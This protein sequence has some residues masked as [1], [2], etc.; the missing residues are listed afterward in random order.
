MDGGSVRPVRIRRSSRLARVFCPAILAASIVWLAAATAFPA[1]EMTS[2]IV[3][4]NSRIDVNIESGSMQASKEDLMKWV[5]WAAESVSAYYGRFPVPQLLLRIVPADGKGVRGGRT[6][7][8][9]NGG[10]ITIHVGKG[11]Q[12]SDLASDWMLTHEM[13][14]LAFPSVGENHHWMEEGIATYVEPIARVRAGH[15]DANQMWFEVVRDLQQGLPAAGDE[16]LDHTHTWGRTYWGGALFCFLADIEIHR[17]TGNKKGL[18]DALR[19]ILAAGG[20]I[21][22]DWE[23][24]KALTVGDQATGVP[25]LQ[26]LYAKMK[27]QPYNVDLPALWTQLGVERDGNAVKFLD[28]APLAKTRDAI[29]YGSAGASLKPAANA[30]RNPAIFAG[31]TAT[32]LPPDKSSD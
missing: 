3:I 17:E 21:R 13:V 15:L 18:E 6:F 27:D 28:A 1:D 19:G 30:S 4:G 29:T 26:N 5:R 14:H 8:R 7:G 10:F 23:L 24:E 12:F 11:A 25:V 31:R 2:T 9:D 22:Y 32:R 16:G 20:D